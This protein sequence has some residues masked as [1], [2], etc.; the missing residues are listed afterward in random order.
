MA[1]AM[2]NLTNVVARQAANAAA[3]VTATAQRIIVEEERLARQQRQDE[4]QAQI[5]G[6]IDFGRLDPPQFFGGADPEKADLWIQEIEEIFRVS[7]TPTETRVDCA[8][9]LLMGEAEYWW[10]GTRMMMESNCVPVT[11]DAFC[12]VFM[13]RYFPISAREEKEAQFLKLFQG[14]MVVAEY[15]A[16]LESLAKHRFLANRVDEAYL[17][18]KFTNGL[19]REIKESVQT[20]GIR[21]F[22]PLVE[23]CREIEAIK[24]KRKDK[25]YR[26]RP[27]RSGSQG[28]GGRDKG[29]RQQREP[30]HRQQEDEKS[31]GGYKPMPTALG[32]QGSQAQNRGVQCFRCAE[33]GHFAAACKEDG[34]LCYNC[35]K[36]GHLSRDSRA[37]KV[38][39][40]VCVTRGTHP[41][42]EERVH[43]MAGTKATDAEEET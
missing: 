8:T 31:Q 1:E 13:D 42:V 14:N 5:R 19:R 29:K 34:P 39:L 23:K 25:W 35:H 30:Y 7:R 32:R 36:P 26:G 9:Y 37:P 21:K 38:E 33:F 17:C 12:V 20:L 28:Q 27:M 3:Q 24:N 16:K 15:A 2:A 40:A 6:L 10:R 43:L 18:A 41:T 11:W 22:Q 4:A